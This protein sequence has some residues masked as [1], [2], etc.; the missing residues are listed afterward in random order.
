MKTA[1]ILILTLLLASFAM[2]ISTETTDRKSQV[3]FNPQE[4]LNAVIEGGRLIW[5]A[6]QAIIN[7]RFNE[8]IGYIMQ[9][10]GI[11]TRI[12]AN[13]IPDKLF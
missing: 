7:E 10:Q 6:Y 1:T 12:T 9:A 2:A 11:F 4:C 3:S 13:C 8:L 5:N